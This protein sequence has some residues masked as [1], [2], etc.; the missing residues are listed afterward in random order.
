MSYDRYVFHQLLFQ[1]IQ[2]CKTFSVVPLPLTCPSRINLTQT[3]NFTVKS[4]KGMFCFDSLIACRCNCGLQNICNSTCWQLYYTAVT[5]SRLFKKRQTE[6]NVTDLGIDKLYALTTNELRVVL[7]RKQGRQRSEIGHSS[8]SVSSSCW[9]TGPKLKLIPVSACAYKDGRTFSSQVTYGATGVLRIYFIVKQQTFIFECCNRIIYQ[10]LIS[11]TTSCSRIRPRVKVINSATA[12]N[13]RR[14][15]HTIWKTFPVFI[16]TCWAS[17]TRQPVMLCK[18]WQCL[19]PSPL[20]Y[21]I[22][23][24]KSAVFSSCSYTAP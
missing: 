11:N 17:K 19:S 7:F 18:D 5:L 1:P 23:Y 24:E 22:Y 15:F 9:R 20:Q 21:T 2:M 6:R 10:Q 12:S 13:V 8:C 3:N 4:V 14:W 16:T